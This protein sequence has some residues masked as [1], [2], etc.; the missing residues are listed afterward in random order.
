[1]LYSTAWSF[2]LCDRLFIPPSAYGR[3]QA[4]QTAQGI[5]MD[6]SAV[7]GNF[8]EGEIS[9]KGF[10]LPSLSRVRGISAEDCGV[11]KEAGH[12]LGKAIPPKMCCTSNKAA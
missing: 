4:A 10:R 1:V 7:Y 8:S 9:S 3:A 6:R 11:S 5:A 2:C 12:L